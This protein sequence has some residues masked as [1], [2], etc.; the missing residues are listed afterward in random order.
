MCYG[1]LH[2]I[3]I[4]LLQHSA[5]DVSQNE[6]VHLRPLLRGGGELGAGQECWRRGQLI[7]GGIGCAGDD[8]EGGAGTG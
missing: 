4:P 6:D 3:D 8:G 1:V 5:S 2:G 7:A